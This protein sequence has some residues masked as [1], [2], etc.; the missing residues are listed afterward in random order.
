MPKTFPDHST[1]RILTAELI[2]GVTL[3][4]AAENLPQTKR[5]EI[6]KRVMSL[7]LEELF[8]FNYMQ[9]DPNPANY[10]YDIEKDKLFLLDFGATRAFPDEFLDNYIEIIKAATEK[11]T[12]KIRELSKNIGFL[13]GEENK[14]MLNA[15]EVF[16]FLF[17]N[18]F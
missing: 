9:T 8:K 2:N 3:D 4:F 7:T 15:H 16:L 1:S 14:A 10:F 6:G 11:Q 5:N 13:T 12:D 17:L 18:F